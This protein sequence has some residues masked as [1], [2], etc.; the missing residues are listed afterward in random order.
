MFWQ[1]DCCGLYGHHLTFSL[2]FDKF[3]AGSQ[4]QMYWFFG[5]RSSNRND[6][7]LLHTQSVYFSQRFRGWWC[8][9]RVVLSFLC[10]IKLWSQQHHPDYSDQIRA[11]NQGPSRLYSRAATWSTHFEPWTCNCLSYR[12]L[13]LSA[14]RG[15]KLS[16]H[17][18]TCHQFCHPEFLH[19]R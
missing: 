1:V 10:Q 3:S 8:F 16:V 14:V 2:R 11:P 7:L 18:V 9:V 5:Y 6:E 13:L 4:G 17:C 12:S 19:E 15:Y